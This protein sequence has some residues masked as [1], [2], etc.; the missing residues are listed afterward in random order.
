MCRGLIKALALC[1]GLGFAVA[2][3]GRGADAVDELV[4]KQQFQE[5][6]KAA[7]GLLAKAE[8][9]PDALAWARALIRVTQLEAGL[10]APEA[11]VKRLKAA[12]WPE[13]LEARA[14]LNLF[15][16]HTLVA[17]LNAYGWEIAQR[18]SSGARIPD[19]KAMT[20]AELY[21]E[22]LHAYQDVW[23]QRDALG[24]IEVAAW[25]EFITPNDFPAGVRDTVRD[26]V[27]YFAVE[28][29]GNTS[30]WQPDE[31]NQAYQQDFKALLKGGGAAVAIDD[32]ASHPL[33]RIGAVL[34]DLEQWHGGRKGA[35]AGALEARLE[36]IRR[37]LGTFSDAGSRK[38]AAA[39]LDEI[40]PRYKALSWWA[41]GMAERAEIANGDGDLV[42]ARDLAAAGAAAFASSPGG[43]RCA[44]LLASLNYPGF[45]LQGMATD[46]A[47]KRSL[48]VTHK[49]VG[50]VYF[51]AFRLDLVGEIEATRDYNILPSSEA[52]ERFASK[53]ADAAWEAA[54]PPTP[55]LKT[56]QTFVTPPFSKP[57][58]WF[59][60]ASATPEF[61]KQANKLLATDLVLSDLVVT[62]R[63]EHGKA[64]NVTVVSGKDGKAVGGAEVRIYAHEYGKKAVLRATKATS[65]TGQAT[66]GVDAVPNG[67][68][69][70]VATKGSD[71]SLDRN[72]QYLGREPAES[73]AKAAFIYTDR[74]IYRPGQTL[75]WKV[76]AYAGS[77]AKAA[78]KVVPEQKVVMTLV[79]GNGQKVGEQSV[80]TNEF[81]SASGTFELPAGRLL[82][83]WSLRSDF[84]ASGVSVRVEEYKRPTFEVQ[85][86]D[87]TTALR[88]NRDAEL[89]GAASYY[90]GLPVTSGKVRWTVTREPVYP[91]WWGWYHGG[92][93]GARVQT[94]ATGAAALEKDGTFKVRFKPEAEE[95]KDEDRKALTYRYVVRADLTDEGGETRS[96]TRAMRLGFVSVDATV[97]LPQA[98]LREK[99]GKNVVTVQRASLDGI[100]RAGAARYRLVALTQPAVTVP[101]ADLP[102]PEPLEKKAVVTAGDRQRSRWSPGYDQNAELARWADGKEV[103]AADLAHA[104]SGKASFELPELAPGAYRIRYETQDEFGATFATFKDLIVAG[105]APLNLP[106]YFSAESTLVKV[107]GKARFLVHSG[108]PGQEILF[109]VF[110]AGRLAERR[111]LTAGTPHLIELPVE[112]KDRGGFGVAVTIVADYQAV[113]Y[114]QP[115]FVPWDDKELTVGFA[116]FRDKLAPGAKETWTVT[117][118]GETSLA[119][120]AE[121]LAYMYDKSLDTF[122]K[123]VAP[124]PLGLFPDRSET[125]ALQLGL[126]AAYAFGL[127]ADGWGE[128]PGFDS[129]RPDELKFYEN[130]GIGGPGLQRRRVSDG[131]AY[132]S[133][134]APVMRTMAAPQA[135]AR[136][137]V[138][139]AEAPTA[140]LDDAA[141]GGANAGAPTP[142]PE[143]RKNF[144][145]TAFFLP[146]LRA[147]ASGAATISF[148]VP[149]AVT[150]WNVW[151]HAVTKDL[152]SGSLHAEARSVKE[153]MVR[154]YL[155]RF[156]REGDAVALKVVVNNASE[157]EL[158]G[159]V[160]VAIVD[161]ATGEHR[162]ALFGLKDKSG[163]FT[164]AKGGGADLTFSLTAPKQ[165]GDYAFLVT[166]TSGGLT[167]AEL[168]P[169]PVLPS[170]THLAQSRFAALRD[171][172]P[173][174]LRFD[175][176]AKTDDPT[177]IDERLVVNVDGQLFYG[178]LKALPYLVAYP[179]E[180]V[181]QTL[182]R[183]LATGIVT[184]VFKDFPAVATMAKTLAK[185]ATRLETFDGGDANRKMALEETPW[186]EE[187]KGGAADLPLLNALDAKVANAER[188]SALAK[189]KKA[190][191][192]D[193]SFPWFPGGQASP[194]MTLYM[195]HGFAKAAEF[196]VPIP[197]DMVTRAWKW[198]GAYFRQH[199]AQE[200]IKKDC[201]WEYLTF[202]NYVASAYPDPSWTAGGLSAQ[203]R[204]QILAHSWKHWK[205]HTPYLKAYLALT[206]KRA[207]READARTVLASIMDTAKTSPDLGTYWQPEDRSW[208]WYNDT[209]ESQAFILRALD[210]IDPKN[211]KTDGLVLWLFLNKKL[212][213]WK[214]TR[215]TAEVIYA[216]A[217]HLK[218]EGSLGA[219]ETASVAVG[220]VEKTFTFAPD[221]YTGLAQVVV[222]GPAI[223][224][225]TMADVKV[226]KTSPGGMMLATATWHFSTDKLPTESRGDLFK[227]ERRYFRRDTS[228]KEPRLVPLA[229]GAE[230][231]TGDQIEVQLALSAQH[232]AEYVHLRDPRAA[233][234]E[235]E[236][237]TSGYKYDLGLNVFEETRDSGTN[238]FF[239]RLP[240]G[241]Y[242]LKYRLRAATGGRF[243]V[244]PATVQSMY[245]PE[246]TAY[247]AGKL[248]TIK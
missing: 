27:S 243:R 76:L 247:S 143:V 93:A 184:S 231:A 95:P 21:Q 228:G 213:H 125:S 194:Y 223:E 193:G 224:P 90:F 30:H 191:A 200:W 52:W 112:A 119:G 67:A 108:L 183:F 212:N 121:L 216:L 235:P 156:L 36:R 23:K 78:F 122:A 178:V 22:A 169:L 148:T 87:P 161:A 107:G 126:G 182:N 166:A 17:Y 225:Q 162:E 15:Y 185:R 248:V 177:R 41:M 40:L 84:G 106:A 229:D 155:P 77:R 37:L 11:A 64:L 61:G 116:T 71:A 244:G 236:S 211:A 86:K 28:L 163:P 104:E 33:V 207:G 69:F 59:V 130:Y 111:R 113:Q 110:R 115:V 151:V 226:Q 190:Q 239:E 48:L 89:T 167:D 233:G 215:A 240:A 153:L 72:Q 73:E 192:A 35:E 14:L 70:I 195:A 187:A 65:D 105:P 202:L 165:I 131:L 55:D 170:R 218:G 210:E 206:L 180:C 149:D 120:A 214:S 29:L 174:T 164:V 230:I 117:V 135:A 56:H 25:K 138:A 160:T 94:V 46:T 96:A 81:G 179:Y 159:E 241:Q 109:D 129:P 45:Q 18:E 102:L 1:L 136:G 16:A 147:D 63:V 181:E 2:R 6:L 237:T 60:V 12:R 196:G 134:P 140:S 238:F 51:R 42:K 219:P 144:A 118:K 158:K 80:T 157:R 83:N 31:S 8:G 123:G 68:A 91:W 53:K 137:K 152:S 189:L 203:E 172:A 38:A 227:V 133:E 26:A 208:L 205:Q 10:S 62:S 127:E 4:E 171:E 204:G 9:Q 221:V 222:D 176:L 98:F 97:T 58:L 85:L 54:L 234:M 13:G 103:A 47:G 198:L 20:R 66:F 3:T 145:E 49:N 175:D 124:R 142:E 220:K 146:H 186:L 24:R 7:E 199:D 154:P 74:A 57:G 245:A 39:S 100:G 141:I 188:E 101:P 79:D 150:A 197:K 88:L 232:E 128:I 201:C 242:T 50:K 82:G 132:P 217:H 34:D 44:A 75:H 5:A 19:L 246:F 209:I 168:R 99:S 173:R 43:K 32:V 139:S 114:E 92:D